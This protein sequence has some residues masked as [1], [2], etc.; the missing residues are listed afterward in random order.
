MNNGFP[1]AEKEAEKFHVFFGLFYDLKWCH[2]FGCYCRCV[3]SQFSCQPF[4]SSF[5]AAIL[6][7]LF[8]VLILKL[9]LHGGLGMAASCV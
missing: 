6:I 8:V 5:S 3:Q 2:S 9:G 7:L 1:P 4:I